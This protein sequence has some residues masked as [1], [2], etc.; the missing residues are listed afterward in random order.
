M[1][2]SRW[3]WNAL[4][5]AL[6]G[7]GGLTMTQFAATQEAQPTKKADSK[8]QDN[9]KAPQKDDEKSTP[10]RK[11]LSTFMRMKLDASQ[12]ILE[13]LAV[14]DFEL[15]Q[16]GAAK[17]EDMS[18]A[19]KWRVTNDPFFREHSNDFQK[20]TKRLAKNAKEGKLE[21]SALTWLEA[22]MQ[23]IECHKWTRANLIADKPQ[24]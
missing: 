15:I 4:A 5:V 6:I 18:A 12:K 10:A 16:E 17:L 8:K 14:E 24:R 13:G 21:G 2:V 23:C 9:A 7:A 22:T 1:K 3:G 11:G 19:E 20:I